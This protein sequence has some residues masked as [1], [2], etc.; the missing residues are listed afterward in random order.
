MHGLIEMK[1]KEYVN[2]VP[3]GY[4]AR[5]ASLD[6]SMAVTD[7]LNACFVEQVGVPEWDEAELKVDWQSPHFDLDTDTYSIWDQSGKLVAYADVWDEAPHVQLQSMGYVL[8][9]YREHGLG[10]ALECWLEARARQV[11]PKAPAG[12]RVVLA[13]SAEFVDQITRDFLDN[14]GYQVARYYNQMEIDLDD[15]PMVAELPAGLHIRT[16]AGDAELA[17]VVHAVRDAF[18]DHWGF[19]LTPFE[20]HLKEWRHWTA[21]DP[22]HDPALWFLVVEGDQIVGTSLCK[23]KT[24]SDPEMGWVN[25]LSVRRPWRRRGLGLALLKHSFRELYRRGQKR[26]GLGVD[27]DSLTGATGL[28]EKAGMWLRRKQVYYE[29]ELRP[30]VVLG[31]QSLSE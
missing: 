8:P 25:S 30:G 27:A 3:N 5:P 24:V 14:R 31:T 15:E 21:N 28:Y 2:R 13:Q 16:Y 17:A 22:Q 26:V 1:H 4:T 19:V 20:D 29:K 7:L 10:T 23:P 12:A 11:V 6:D 9:E 18:R